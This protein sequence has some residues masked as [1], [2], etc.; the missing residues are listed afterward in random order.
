MLFVEPSGR[1]TLSDLLKGKGKMSDLLCGCAAARA[2]T[3]PG[4]VPDTSGCADHNWDPEEEDDGDEWLKSIGTCSVPSQ[5]RQ[6]INIS[7]SK[8]KKSLQ[9]G[10]SS[11]RPHQV[12]RSHA[13]M[14]I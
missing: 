3:K 8:S 1:C 4:N 11:R 9:N 7:K 6:H 12:F 13:C 5:L 14:C 2:R 10:S